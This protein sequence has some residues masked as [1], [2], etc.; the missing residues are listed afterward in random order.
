MSFEAVSKLHPDYL[1]IKVSID[2]SPELLPKFFNHARS[3]VARAG[4]DRVLIDALDFRGPVSETDRFLTGQV[5][6]ELF[7]PRIKVALVVPGKQITKLGEISA[8]NRGGRF[9]VSPTPDEALRW[10]LDPAT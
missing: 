7:G 6:A 5:V 1:E 3:E 8:A 4:A 9:F 10:L 2:Y